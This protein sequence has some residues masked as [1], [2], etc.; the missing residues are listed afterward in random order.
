MD[1][2][3]V[4]A[5]RP[6]KD[7]LKSIEGAADRP[8]PIFVEI[9]EAQEEYLNELIQLA[10]KKKLHEERYWLLLGHYKKKMG[11]YKSEVFTSYY[12][13]AQDGRK[14]PESELEYT[15]R[16]FFQGDLSKTPGLPHPRC[17]FQAR[18]EWLD[19]ALS[20]DEKR[21]PPVDCAP[22]YKWRKSLN[23][24][25]LSVIFASYYMGNPSSMF[26][27][28][29]L[30]LNNEKH[31]G[32]YEILDYGV[33]YA[34][35]VN[36]EDV[37]TLSLALM[38]FLG[39]YPGSFSLFPYY[40]KIREYNDVD[41][42]ELWEYKLNFNEEEISRV[43][44]H[45]WEL[46][47]AQFH[48]YFFDKNCSYQLLTL[49]E[50][51]RPDLSVSDEFFY[52]VMPPDTV[53]VLGKAGV[54]ESATN[55]LSLVGKY[56]RRYELLTKP[57]RKMLHQV[58]AGKEIDLSQIDEARKALFLDAALDFFLITKN[59]GK[60]EY[61]Q[62]MHK[63]ILSERASIKEKSN[64]ELPDLPDSTDPLTSH[65]SSRLFLSNGVD[66]NGENITSLTFNPA[67]HALND[68]WIGF[69]PYSQLLFIS[70]TVDYVESQNKAY[71]NRLILLDI[72]SLAPYLKYNIRARS[73]RFSFGWDHEP[74]PR[75]DDIF[76]YSYFEFGPG[77]S[78][79]THGYG[80]LDR[81]LF[82]FLV[83]P[84]IEHSANFDYRLRAVNIT[85]A[86]IHWRLT[87]WWSLRVYW[88]HRY[89][90]DYTSLRE[91]SSVV[92]ESNFGI[93]R[94]LALSIGGVYKPYTEEYRVE[95]GLKFYF[96]Y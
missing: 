89:L 29:L 50:V 90:Y 72:I 62:E 94:R 61:E 71:L 74:A 31:S 63:Q 87:D 21:L 73:W 35:A 92:G 23:P 85:E 59:T 84:R 53:K 20:I 77:L 80:I 68:R 79:A 14:N 49:L 86:G 16:A 57:E 44:S 41:N 55:R 42:R 24:K 54:I 4:Q 75:V 34:A 1:T 78:F 18:Y 70:T 43:M 13:M 19:A 56:Q 36:T 76:N 91:R 67:L 6:E 26:G 5:K 17:T 7:P 69:S 48:Y 28:T 25:S 2:A 51:G 96:Q 38:G 93:G 32:G 10:R 37:N 82:V 40:M 52:Q 64:Y 95:G 39:G 46:R 27:H 12:F 66:H 81:L 33:N 65:E 83:R 11:G 45:L 3:S 8:P 22:Y 15:L 88:E 47:A 30:K 60:G 58:S 9:S